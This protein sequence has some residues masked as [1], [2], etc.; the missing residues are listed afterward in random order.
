MAGASSARASRKCTDSSVPLIS[1]DSSRQAQGQRRSADGIHDFFLFAGPDGI[2][3]W[4]RDRAKGHLEGHGECPSCSRIV[5]HFGK[6]V[7]PMLSSTPFALHA[8][9]SSR[10]YEAQ[11]DGR[12]ATND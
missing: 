3:E 4:Q 12:R 9:M 6:V 1:S 7:R 10:R 8:S 5:C 2:K 11:S